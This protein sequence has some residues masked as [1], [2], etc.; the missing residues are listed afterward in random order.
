MQAAR[1]VTMLAGG[2]SLLVCAACSS[3][4]KPSVSVASASPVSPANGALVIQP[5]VPLQPL[6]GSFQRKR[7]TFSV[8][9]AG[10]T[11]P[12]ASL[13][14]LFEVATDTAF[15]ALVASGTAPEGPSQTSFMPISDLASGAMFYWRARA[16][17]PLTGVTS[18]YSSTQSFTTVNP[19][20]GSFPYVFQVHAPR[21]CQ[22]RFGPDYATTNYPTDLVVSGDTLRF[23]LTQL[24]RGLHGVQFRVDTDAGALTQCGLPRATAIYNVRAGRTEI[25]RITGYR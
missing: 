1:I 8:T 23:S 15:S 5:P 20:D 21:S 14:Y 25:S 9:N 18:S 12:A 2:A 11:G 6:S 22:L 17:D 7:M 3:P 13:T 10:R 24:L 16:A 4:T 19:D